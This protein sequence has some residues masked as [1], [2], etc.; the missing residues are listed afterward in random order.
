MWNMQAA[1]AAAGGGTDG[2]RSGVMAYGKRAV[3]R[4]PP[5]VLARL[6]ENRTDKVVH[7]TEVKIL[8]VLDRTTP[9]GE[10]AFVSATEETMGN[11]KNTICNICKKEKV[12]VELALRGTCS[13]CMREYGLFA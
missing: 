7:Q 12:D 1:L 8:K 4:L 9:L 11:A 10:D 6:E 2:E 13:D 5:E 3:V